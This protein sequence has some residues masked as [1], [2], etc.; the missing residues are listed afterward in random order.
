[1]DSGDGKYLRS[2]HF[3]S[4]KI[5]KPGNDAFLGGI[6]HGF[7]SSNEADAMKLYQFLR[8]FTICTPAVNSADRMER[9][10]EKFSIF[11]VAF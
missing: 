6:S 10:V 2:E 11:F 4:A 5:P 3:L 9:L 7:G 8:V 1:M